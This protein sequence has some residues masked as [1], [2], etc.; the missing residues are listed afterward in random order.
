MA[1][2]NLY[3]GTAGPLL[4]GSNHKL[5]HDILFEDNLDVILFVKPTILHKGSTAAKNFSSSDTLTPDG[6]TGG[7]MCEVL[8]EGFHTKSCWRMGG[9]SMVWNPLLGGGGWVNSTSDS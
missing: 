9:A 2:F 3:L 7:A 6:S 5:Y 4:P 8:V 1:S